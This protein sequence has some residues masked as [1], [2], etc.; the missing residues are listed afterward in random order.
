M[1]T[2][3]AAG[4]LVTALGLTETHGTG[5]SQVQALHDVSFGLELG[6]FCV[7]HGP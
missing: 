7:L 1:T 2:P 5:S 3:A 4:P 6:S